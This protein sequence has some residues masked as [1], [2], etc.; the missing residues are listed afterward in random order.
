MQVITIT[1]PSTALTASAGVSE[2]AG[3]GPSG[4]GKIRITNPQGGTPFPAPNYYL[5]S[6]DNQATWVTSNEAY[7][8]PG[9]YT[10][11]I[12]DANGCIYPMPNVIIEAEPVAPTIDVASPVFNCDGSANSTVTITNPGGANF[13]YGYL[14]DG[15]ANTNVPSNVFVNVPSG[16]HTVSVT[17]KLLTVPTYSNLLKE[18]FGN[19]TFAYTA[20]ASPDVSSPGINPAFCWERQIDATR[21][22]GNRLFANGEYTVTSSLRNDPYSGWHNPVDHTAGSTTGRYLAVDAGTAIPN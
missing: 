22:N 4:E 18:D 21:C 11:Y 10:V 20:T 15:T 6:F 3:C 13:E 19:D 2:L 9:T 12:K 17:Y 14:L 1:Q 7:V 8:A 5:Y 16:S